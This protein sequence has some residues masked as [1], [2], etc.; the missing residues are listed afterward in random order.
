MPSEMS[1]DEMEAMV[2][3]RFEELD[4]GNF[5]VL[6]ELF[7]PS[8]QLNVPGLPDPLSLDA[9][10]R[11][12]QQLYAAFP[13]LKH[14]IVEQMSARN[15]AVTRWVATGTHKGSFMGVASTGNRV[16]FSGINVYT[17][18]HRKFVQSQVN[19]DLLTLFR[20]IGAANLTAN[21]SVDA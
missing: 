7:D 12:Y 9:T 19:W 11:F 3:R 2:R 17:I 13:D 14:T 15:K 21:L 20:Q 1:F 16:E 6:D 18:E 8:Y 5:S 10:K 4:R